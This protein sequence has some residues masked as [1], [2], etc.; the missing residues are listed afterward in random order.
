MRAAGAALLD[1]DEQSQVGLKR[2]HVQLHALGKTET[3]YG[4]LLE[5]MPVTCRDGSI[6]HLEYINPF[7]LMYF[8]TRESPH[9]AKFVIEWLGDTGNIGIY[10]DEVAPTD[11][12]KFDSG[13]TYTAVYYTFLEYPTGLRVV[14]LVG[15]RSRTL[16]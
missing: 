5:E 12:L 3:P 2:A 15:L 6:I 14:L 1:A 16:R 11:G 9:Y 10:N 7:A 13:R 4:R 8:C